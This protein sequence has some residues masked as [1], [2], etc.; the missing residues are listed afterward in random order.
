MLY[1]LELGIGSVVLGYVR[2]CIAIR[3]GIVKNVEFIRFSVLEV[4][5]QPRCLK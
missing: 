4:G 2:N 3:R 1:G 5:L